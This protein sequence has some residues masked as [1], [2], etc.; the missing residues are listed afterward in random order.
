MRTNNLTPDEPLQ[1]IDRINIMEDLYL[2]HEYEDLEGLV[3]GE[4]ID[5]EEFYDSGATIVYLF[6]GLLVVAIV[7]IIFYLNA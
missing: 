1:N 5:P 6:L 2:S 7:A 3:Y 4:S